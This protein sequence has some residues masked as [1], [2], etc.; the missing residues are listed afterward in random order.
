MS[1]EFE[2]R[3][4]E[5]DWRLVIDA[6]RSPVE[7]MALDEALTLAVAKGERAPT[8]RIWEWAANAVVLGRF[9]SVRNEVDPVGAERHGMN[10]VR[11]IT[12]GGAMF[13]E[14]QNAITYSVYAPETLVKG[15]SFIDSYAF[16]DAWVIKGLRSLGVEAEYKPINDISSAA[17]KIGGAAQT[18]RLG[19]VLHHVTMAYDMEP[20]KMLEVLRIGREKLSDKGSVSANK[21]VTPLRQQTQMPRLDVIA[22]LTGTFTAA[23]GATVDAVTATEAAEAERLVREK[24]ETDE[25]LYVLP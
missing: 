9:Q 3:W 15:M 1:S 6:P 19:A 2:K 20:A 12:G 7:Q 24:F 4:L 23:Y 22:A 5:H 14:P 11:R 25:W 8:L 16:M 17:G 10:V 21:R 18:R 13:V